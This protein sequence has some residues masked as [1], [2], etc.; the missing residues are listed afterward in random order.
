[1]GKPFENFKADDVNKAYQEVLGRDAN[2]GELQGFTTNNVWFRDVEDLKRGIA[3]TQEAQKKGVDITKYGDSYI[4]NAT[5]LDEKQAEIFG[6]LKEG[7]KGK[8]ILKSELDAWTTYGS[9]AK[10]RASRAGKTVTL[11]NGQADVYDAKSL[12]FLTNEAGEVDDVHFRAGDVFLVPKGTLLKGRLKIAEDGAKLGEE[13]AGY[14]IVSKEAR[15]RSGVVGGVAKSIGFSKGAAN[16]FDKA[17][18]QV[19]TV[20]ATA[21]GGGAGFVLSD[22][23]AAIAGGTRGAEA[24]AKQFKGLGVSEKNLQTLDMVGDVA[25]SV[26]AMAVDVTVFKGAPIASS[27]NQLANQMEAESLG[28]ANSESWKKMATNIAVDWATHGI[29]KGLTAYTRAKQAA[30]VADTTGKTVRAAKLAGAANTAW[31]YGSPAAGALARG[32]TGKDA[33]QSAAVAAVVGTIPSGPGSTFGPAFR[34]ATAGSLSYALADKDL[35]SRDRMIGAGAAAAGTYTSAVL[36][37]PAGAWKE[38]QGDF[39]IG[40]VG[41]AQWEASFLRSPEY[42]KREADYRAGATTALEIR[43]PA[44]EASFEPGAYLSGDQYLAHDPGPINMSDFRQIP[45]AW[46][47]RHE[48]PPVA[49]RTVVPVATP[50]RR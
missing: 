44:Y 1:M 16:S 14:D 47:S 9:A 37:R 45:L 5:G 21:I 7:A 26:A 43:N 2:K 38:L 27:A 31:R 20:A 49:T 32:G 36:T 13:Y 28:Y 22:E 39:G 50:T 29:G 12:S 17:A 35:S 15:K 40:Q 3:T 33:L 30:A 25:T 18:G 8:R 46:S 11:K 19:A 42:A 48:T 34:A 6:I 10:L 24:R 41:Q 23:A 4:D